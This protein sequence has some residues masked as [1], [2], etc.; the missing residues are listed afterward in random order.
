MSLDLRLFWTDS[1]LALS[2]G[3][4]WQGQGFARGEAGGSFS[5][6][7]FGFSAGLGVEATGAWEA[8]LGGWFSRD[9]WH[10]SGELSFLPPE[11][12]GLGLR[13]ALTWDTMTLEGV[14]QWNGALHAA[15]ALGL[16]L[17]RLTLQGRG[18][19]SQAG[20]T[21]V[22]GAAEFSGEPG[23]VGLGIDFLPLSQQCFF[24]SNLGVESEHISFGLEAVWALA[25][26]AQPVPAGRL[27]HGQADQEG[28]LRLLKELRLKLSVTAPEETAG[29]REEGPLAFIATP[30][31]GTFWVDEAIRFSARGSRSPAGPIAEVLWDFGD[32][33]QAQGWDVSH[34]YASPGVYRVKLSVRDAQGQWAQAERILRVT[35]PP[36]SADFTW[37]PAEPTVLDTVCFSD[38]SRGDVVAWHW[39]FGDGQT[40]DQRAP[41]H[42]YTTKGVH[43]VSLTVTDRHG[44]KAK[45]TK[46]LTVVNIPPRAD[47]GGPYQGLVSGEITF[48]AAKSYDPDGQIV[49]YIWS[50]GDGSTAR[51]R[52]VSHVYRKPGVY[53]V[54][55]RVVDDNG[56]EATACTRATVI[57]PPLRG[58]P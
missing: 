45:T 12:M 5:F 32:G 7:P 24:L 53:E 1:S 19:F 34:R 30:D 3:G 40:S 22:H 4:R 52:I 17:G 50:F 57:A 33:T 51:G 27:S 41:C 31:K 36:L 10:L 49:E 48:N 54:C 38:L 58:T 11:R 37:E 29:P 28:P 21:R 14:L 25:P 2:L 8:R 43:R 47:P 46:T 35:L 18:E 42:R 20:I 16:E 56:A 55:L 23:E 26:A 6:E 13:V 39:E 44:N 15:V 9:P